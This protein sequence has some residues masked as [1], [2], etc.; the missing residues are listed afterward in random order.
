M[1]ANL[2]LVSVQ[3]GQPASFP[4]GEPGGKP[5]RSAIV[6]TAVEGP[7]WARRLGL[8]GD[9]QADRR[10]HGG[11][12][13]AINV[14]PAEHYAFWQRMPGLEAMRGGAFGENFTT[15]GLVESNACIGDLF[16]VGTALVQI[17][18]PRGPCYKLNRRWNAPDLQRISEETHRFGWYLRVLEEGQV[19]AGDAMH[20]LEQPN[21]QWTIA[22]VWDLT[23]DPSDE[24]AARA[25]LALPAL[26]SD[27]K[28]SLEKQLAR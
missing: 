1:E 7:V 2:Q 16:R 22:T 13:R 20:L 6:K 21:P 23:L 28:R 19:Q 24:A 5:W 3:V 15:L 8:D 4:P 14:Y 11:E 10:V 12:N 9:A 18:Q 25:L 17:T 26:S 27:W